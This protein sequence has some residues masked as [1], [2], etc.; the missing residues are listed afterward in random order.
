MVLNGK[1]F[2]PLMNKGFIS[3]DGCGKCNLLHTAPSCGIITIQNIERVEDTL[4]IV[5]GAALIG[6]SPPDKKTGF[7]IENLL[8]FFIF[9]ANNL[10]HKADY[11]SFYR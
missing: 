7:I 5:D 10:G 6:S 11:R 3:G 2:S 9:P 4:Y 8:I 1:F